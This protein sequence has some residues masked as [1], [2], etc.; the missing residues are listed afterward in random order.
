VCDPC[1][2]GKVRCPESWC[3]CAT[4]LASCSSVNQGDAFSR[5]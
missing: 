2:S 1:S 5:G 4:S 3:G